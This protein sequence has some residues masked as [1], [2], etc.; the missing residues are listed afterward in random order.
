MLQRKDFIKV[1]IAEISRIID[2]YITR[3]E[4]IQKRLNMKLEKRNDLLK[5]LR[6]EKDQ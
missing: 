2:G 3:I 4:E 5:E 6:K 1:E